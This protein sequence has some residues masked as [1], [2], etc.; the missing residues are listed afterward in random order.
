MVFQKVCQGCRFR[1]APVLP[2]FKNPNRFTLSCL[3]GL[4]LH[5]ELFPFSS[6]AGCFSLSVATAVL[7]LV[8]Q[9][10]RGVSVYAANCDKHLASKPARAARKPLSKE[11]L[12]ESTL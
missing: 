11:N 6:L 9:E 12:Q 8:D 4:T 10:H 7:L 1:I 5:P 2:K 3:P